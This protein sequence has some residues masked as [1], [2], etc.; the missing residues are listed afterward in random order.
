MTGFYRA[1]IKDFATIS[2]P[3][4]KLT[5]DNVKFTWDASCGAAF[6]ELK[7]HL[8]C[9]PIL[10][11]PKL[12]DPFVFEVDASDYAAGGVLSQTGDDNVLHPIIYF[13]TSFT[14]SQRNWAPVTKRLL[15]WL[16]V[17]HWRVHLSGTEFILSSDHNPLVH[18]RN[19]KD[20]CGKFGLWIAELEEYN[21]TVQ[22]IRGKDNVKADF[23]SRNPAANP[24]QPHSLFDDKV[25]AINS[26]STALVDQFK[27][28]QS[29][30]PVISNTKRLIENGET[31]D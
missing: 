18:L 8:M 13:S 2:Q 11:F 20:P 24:I 22:C 29:T 7:K 12:D 17:R 14:R 5:G 1:F 28:E 31:I 27:Q 26:S 30:N 4:N 3:L 21:Y 9:E 25:F 6:Q 15:R 19:Q 23:L 10:A 16:A